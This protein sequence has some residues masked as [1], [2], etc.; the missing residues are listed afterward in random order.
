LAAVLD[1]ICPKIKH[2]R[3]AQLISQ[4]LRVSNLN[5]GVIKEGIM[6]E[7]LAV[8]TDVLNLAC[9]QLGVLKNRARS[10]NV[11]LRRALNN[12]PQRYRLFA[13]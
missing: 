6:V 7:R 12:R 1:I 5:G 10:Q 13:A 9:V 2:H 11:N 4:E 8:I 3:Y